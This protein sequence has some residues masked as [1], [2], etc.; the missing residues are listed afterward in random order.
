M[1]S[2]TE[3]NTDKLQAVGEVAVEL[4]GTMKEIRDD[5]GNVV[6]CALAQ[7]ALE[8]IATN[9]AVVSV[10]ASLMQTP[11]SRNQSD[12][13]KITEKLRKSS[14]EVQKALDEIK[15]IE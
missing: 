9:T 8:T 11:G 5:Q 6:L 14:E 2:E 1:T 15:G 4:K 10:I 12:I 7:Q 13:M 3:S